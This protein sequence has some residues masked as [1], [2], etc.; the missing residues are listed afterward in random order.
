VRDCEYP[1]ICGRFILDRAVFGF[2]P[3]QAQ[4]SPQFDNLNFK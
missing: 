2:P 3:M 4:G 1:E